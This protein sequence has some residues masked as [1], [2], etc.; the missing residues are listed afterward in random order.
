MKFLLLI[1]ITLVPGALLSE[2]SEQYTYRAEFFFGDLNEGRDYEDVK[3]QN[4]EYLGFLKE[5]D[6]KYGRALFIPIWSG[7]R[8]Y[9]II[10]Y[11]YWPSG[12]E[13]Y[14]EW[15][16]YM[17]KYPAWAEENS[18]YEGADPVYA[19]S[20]TTV[21]RAIS[22]RGVR[23]RGIQIPQEE[24]DRFNFVDFRRCELKNQGSIEKLLD[25]NARVEAAEIEMG[26]RAG[27]GIHYLEPYRGIDE[28]VDYDFVIMR[29]YYSAE[30]RSSIVTSSPSFREMMNKNGFYK[31]FRRYAECGP[32]ST[33]RVEWL[34]N[35]YQD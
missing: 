31:E 8:E 25:L 18:Q 17:N 27:Y 35:S 9:D 26:N 7:E 24:R 23:A 29:H 16:A 6:L 10:E 21:K 32:E 5:N 11:G 20:A 14:R 30:M 4:M 3:A 34:Y 19:G 15:G 28:N 22:M 12:E 1:L 2:T 33:F 13:Q